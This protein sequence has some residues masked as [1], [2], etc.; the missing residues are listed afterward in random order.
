M[1]SDVREGRLDPGILTRESRID[2]ALEPG[3]G[4]AGVGTETA[5]SLLAGHAAAALCR[6]VDEPAVIDL[7]RPGLIVELALQILAS[8]H[9]N[10]RLLQVR[11]IGRQ[12]SV[13][14]G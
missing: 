10:Q 5:V 4:H 13:A 8:G 2:H 9:E 1:A 6:S 12:P 14:Q 3:V 7:S 11:V